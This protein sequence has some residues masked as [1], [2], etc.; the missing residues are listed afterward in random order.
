M[1]KV[2]MGSNLFPFEE[3]CIKLIVSYILG[4]HLFPLSCNKALMMAFSLIILEK[5]NTNSKAD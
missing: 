5:A 3:F 2:Q 1:S 4:K